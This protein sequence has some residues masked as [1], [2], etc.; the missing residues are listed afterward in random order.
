MK[1]PIENVLSEAMLFFD[2]KNLIDLLTDIFPLSHLYD[3]ADD[4]S[5]WVI[6]EVGEENEPNVRLIRTL[7]LISKIAD[8]HAG[9]LSLFKCKFPGLFKRLEKESKLDHSE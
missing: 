1:K 3:I 5:D 4:E 7:Y 9:K 2:S 6:E 8:N